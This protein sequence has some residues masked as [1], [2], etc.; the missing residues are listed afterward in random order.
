MNQSETLASFV[1]SFSESYQG[2]YQ[3]RL[4][5]KSSS[6]EAS[7]RKSTPWTF[8]QHLNKLYCLPAAVCP[9]GVSVC[10]SP[11]LGT[12]VRAEALYAS[13]QHA[14]ER[15]ARCENHKMRR[16]FETESERSFVIMFLI[17]LVLLAHQMYIYGFKR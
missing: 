3:F 2:I 9:V 17:M 7:Y 16:E 10:S 8:S 4:V 11:P 14:H 13:V 15:V 6:S 1:W 5:I 12:I